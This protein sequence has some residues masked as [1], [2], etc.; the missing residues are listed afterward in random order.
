MP[1]SDSTLRSLRIAVYAVLAG[2]VL[3]LCE[4]LA[5]HAQVAP[6]I[7]LDAHGDAETAASNPSTHAYQVTV[8]LRFGHLD[9]NGNIIVDS[10]LVAGSLVSP[11]HFRLAPGRQ[12][13][14]RMRVPKSA[15][16]PAGTVLRLVTSYDPLPALTST[17]RVGETPGVSVAL[18]TR[19]VFI[20]KV[21][22]P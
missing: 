20:G 2:L 1:S 10:G 12:Q 7:I 19:W 4:V 5:L 14:V 21:L 17:S 6:S 11:R 9:M 8:A 15:T 22:V 16:V 18:S 13:V 3:L